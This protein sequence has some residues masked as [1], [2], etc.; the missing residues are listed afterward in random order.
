VQSYS[1]FAPAVAKKTLV[2][3]VFE[4]YIAVMIKT[5]ND[6]KSH[7]DIIRLWGTTVAYGRA[8]GIKSIAAHMHFR[9][10]SIPSDY[11]AKV[12]AQAAQISHPFITF[13]LLLKLKPERLPKRIKSGQKHDQ[14]APGFSEGCGEARREI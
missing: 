4:T 1:D 13:E 3:Q 14:V 11:W 8:I 2:R 6:I 5:A 7:R 10:S 9:R 12:V